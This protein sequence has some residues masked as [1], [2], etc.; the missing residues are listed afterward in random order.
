VPYPTPADRK[1]LESLIKS[2]WQ[3]KVATPYQDWDTPRLQHY[4]KAKGHEAKKG[5]GSSKDSLVTQ[6][7]SYWDD[8]ADTASDSY[9]NIK[10]WVFDR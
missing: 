3:S 8:T 1:D 6:V 2:N 10:D 7:K 4:L 5:A 9:G